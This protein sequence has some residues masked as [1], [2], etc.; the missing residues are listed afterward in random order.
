MRLLITPLLFLVL[1]A[2]AVNVDQDALKD[3]RLVNG[4]AIDGYSPVS[5]FQRDQAEKGNPEFSVTHQGI[6]YWL[7]D[8]EQVDLFQQNPDKYAPA[9][10]GW[11]SLML[12]GSGSR[13][14]ANPESWKIVDDRLL[15]F[16]SGDYKGMAISGLKNWHSKTNREYD[17]ELQRLGVADQT[18]A[19]ILNGERESEIQFFNTGDMERVSEAQKA[20]GKRMDQ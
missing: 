10:G 17:Q 11:C 2:Q 19:A 4:L 12:S 15:L 1:T 13:T 18:W 9:H 8:Q 5:Y 7:T 6:T 16:W 3:Y 20:A 14:P